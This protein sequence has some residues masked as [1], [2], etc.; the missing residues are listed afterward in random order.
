M[1]DTSVKERTFIMIKPDGVQRGLI[2]QIISR[3]ENKAFKLCAIKLCTPERAHFEQHYA[4]L[5]SKGL[6]SGLIDYACSGPVCAMVW[7]GDN[8]VA[9]SRKM[10]GAADPL[11]TEPGTIRGDLCIHD[12]RDIIYCSDSV[13]TANS[14]IN[15]W[16][17]DDEISA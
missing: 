12:S 9:T 16:F 13:E 6:F 14:E 15:L 2:G 8:V 17:K 7:E 11:D 3:F 5:S 4:H 10:L 1:I